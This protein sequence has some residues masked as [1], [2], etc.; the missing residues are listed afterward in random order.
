MR[1]D[2][3]IVGIVLVEDNPDDAVFTDRVLRRCGL[4][5]G[6]S[7]CTSGEDVVERLNARASAGDDA[8]VVLLDLGLPGMSGLDVLRTI[9]A[10]PRHADTI[11][12]V[13]TGA[14][15]FDDI[16]AAYLAG[17]SAVMFKPIDFGQFV[18]RMAELG[19]GWQLLGPS[20]AASR[21]AVAADARSPWG[22]PPPS[23]P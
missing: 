22:A 5:N 3:A 10:D 2:R 4:A 16:S 12:I 14:N 11:V 13:L 8:G 18:E 6:L 19:F 9:R 1:T 15:A 7:L 23:A 21:L 20:T 17:A